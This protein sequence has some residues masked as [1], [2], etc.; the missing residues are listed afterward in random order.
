MTCDTCLSFLTGADDIQQLK[1]LESSEFKQLCVMIGMASKP[2][3]V[4]RF[5]KALQRQSHLNP[6]PPVGV[7][8]VGIAASTSPHPSSHIQPSPQIHT[9]LNRTAATTGAILRPL[10]IASLNPTTSSSPLQCPPVFAGGNLPSAISNSAT[11]CQQTSSFIA[12]PITPQSKY[13]TVTPQPN[14]SE[15]ARRLFLPPYLQ[16]GSECRSFDDLVDD[17]TPVQ[18][19]LGP[20]PFSPSVWD[21]KR[22]EVIQ[23]HSAIYGQNASKRKNGQLNAFEVNVNEAAYQLCLRDPTLLVRREELF[24]LA[25]RAVKEGGYTF[26]HGFSKGK[27][28][29][30]SVTLGGVT[31]QKRHLEDSEDEDPQSLHATEDLY[32]PLTE[33]KKRRSDRIRALEILIATNKSEQ[34]V[35]LAALE[36]AQQ[37]N[38]FSTAY[39]IQLEIESLGNK[40]MTLQM[41]YS[42]LKKKQRRSERYYKSKQQVKVQE[43]EDERACISN[44]NDVNSLFSMATTSNMRT[45]THQTTPVHTVSV[46]SPPEC[47][48]LPSSGSV[49]SIDHDHSL[50]FTHR[51]HT[52][53]GTTQPVPFYHSPVTAQILCNQNPQLEIHNEA[54]ELV[55]T[56]THCASEVSRL[57]M[58][59]DNTDS[60]Q[61]DTRTS[62]TQAQNLDVYRP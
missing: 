24:T 45:L 58:R 49:S 22:A 52:A 17:L 50:E 37:S 20:S 40:Y 55:A 62:S 42:S 59:F 60:L 29:E 28:C 19:T 54:E 30:N 8:P 5:Q 39:H 61:T 11:T 10:H 31:P 23:K 3:H 35:K 2:F 14:Q 4:M 27:E 25:R 6:I 38:D 7:V 32:Q 1:E 15:S 33:R 57:L 13:V 9:P 53:S 51:P 41:E 12:I 21:T 56:V 43:S 34:S 44:T 47:A 26:Y 16:P 46:T 18:K 48:Q 36:K